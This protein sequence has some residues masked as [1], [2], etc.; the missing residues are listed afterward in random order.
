ML[1]VV[2][3]AP[4][5]DLLAGPQFKPQ[6]SGYASTETRFH[7]AD[8]V[9]DCDLWPIRSDFGS[10]EKLDLNKMGAKT[11]CREPNCISKLCQG[12]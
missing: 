3:P 5:Q 1:K 11:E 12:L 6:T 10:W 4:S 9:T 2:L 7:L 8:Q